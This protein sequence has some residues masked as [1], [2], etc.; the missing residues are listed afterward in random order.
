MGECGRSRASHCAAGPA[1]SDGW[2][3][4]GEECEA[5]SRP[6][7]ARG[8]S[9]PDASKAGLARATAP[10]AADGVARTPP[11]TSSQSKCVTN[12][13]QIISQGNSACKTACQTPTHRKKHAP[14]CTTTRATREQRCA[15]PRHR[16]RPEPAR[17]VNE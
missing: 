2:G 6:R 13:E 17:A 1:S 5:A 7:G 15:A 9:G 10:V 11:A 16:Q 14:H 8:N 3:S 12:L 4:P